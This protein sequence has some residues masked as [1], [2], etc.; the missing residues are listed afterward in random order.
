M[1]K[2]PLAWSRSRSFITAPGPAKRFDSLWHRLLNRVFNYKSLLAVCKNITFSHTKIVFCR[3]PTFCKRGEGD[4]KGGAWCPSCAASRRPVVADPAP[5]RPP[6]PTRAGKKYRLCTE[7][8]KSVQNLAK[9]LKMHRGVKPDRSG[10]LVSSSTSDFCRYVFVFEIRVSSKQS[11]FFFG[12]NR[13]KPK[14]NLFR[15][16]F[17][18]FRETKQHFFLVC[19][20]VSYRYRNNRNIQKFLET[21]RKNLQK[22][23]S[24]RGSLKPLIFFSVRTVTNRNSIC[25]S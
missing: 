15:L 9:H 6:P 17:G 20:G 24:I 18:L 25:F 23:F 19:F 12:S 10:A 14:L 1:C 7:C 21:N 16:F 8:G 2:I 13:N 4:E 5:S 3:L 11:N 22:T